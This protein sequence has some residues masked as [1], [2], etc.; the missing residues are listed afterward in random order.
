MCAVS[1]RYP[2]QL[3]AGYLPELTQQSTGT[4]FERGGF[5]CCSMSPPGGILSAA[6]VRARPL[7]SPATFDR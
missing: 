4:R 7:P 5:R 6:R 2:R 1:S 3:R